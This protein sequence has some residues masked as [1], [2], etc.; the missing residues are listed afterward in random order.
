VADE[1]TCPSI[2]CGHRWLLLSTV[3][4]LLLRRAVQ[5]GRGWRGVGLEQRTSDAAEEAGRQGALMG[6][7]YLPPIC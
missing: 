4:W 1:V 6:T 5:M 3:S 7:R 2:S